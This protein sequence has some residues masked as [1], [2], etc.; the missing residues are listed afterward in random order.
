MSGSPPPV[1]QS[2]RS[3][4]LDGGAVPPWLNNSAALGWRLIAIAL[5]AGAL[6][7]L[8]KLLW[9]V[10][11]SIAVGVVVAAVFAPA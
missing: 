10:A 5:F 4:L 6:L 3:S 2:E 1:A 9:I 7:L 11:A 8:V